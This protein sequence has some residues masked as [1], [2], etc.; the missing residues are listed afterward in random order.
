MDLLFDPQAWIALATP[1]RAGAGA[2]HRQHHLHQHPGTKLPKHQQEKARRLGLF[3]AMFMRIGLLLMLSWIVGMVEPLF[4]LPVF[5]QPISG[6]DI[7]LL[8]GGLF[9]I[10]K[11]TGEIHGSLEGGTSPTVPARRRRLWRRHPADHGDRSGLSRST[12]SS[13]PWAWWTMCA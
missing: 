4:T 3:M 5:N 9:L 10:W 11:S 12:P 6:R 13:P 7:I 2:G 1:H 8:S